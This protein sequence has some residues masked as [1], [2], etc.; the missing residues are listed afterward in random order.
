MDKEI[1]QTIMAFM[2]RV[3]LNGKEVR[4]FTACMSELA[5]HAQPLPEAKEETTEE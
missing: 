4:A 5:K 3:N 2:E 1:A